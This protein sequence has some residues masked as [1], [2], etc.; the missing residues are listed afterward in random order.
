MS[1]SRAQ[2]WLARRNRRQEDA[3]YEDAWWAQQCGG[4]FRYLR[5]LGPIGEDW[6]VCANGKSPFDGTV[7]FEHDGCDAF[8]AAD[9]DWRFG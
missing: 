1:R 7:R 8:A 2:R 9:D 3:D 6:G 4:C 5:L